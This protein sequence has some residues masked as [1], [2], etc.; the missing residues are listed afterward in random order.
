MTL[1]KC[2]EGGLVIDRCEG[3]KQRAVGLAS[4]TLRSGETSDVP[5]NRSELCMDHSSDLSARQLY[6]L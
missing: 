2:R 5:E 6:P 1:H 4:G 3:M